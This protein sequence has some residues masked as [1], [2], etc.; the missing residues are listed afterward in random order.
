[1][2]E[3]TLISRSVVRMQKVNKEDCLTI[4]QAAAAV[5]SS[6]ATLYNYMNILGIQRLKFPFDRRTYVMKVDVE[7]MRRF[8]EENRG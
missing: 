7:R 3:Q 4:E 8:V 1:M 6:K 2:Y 5:G